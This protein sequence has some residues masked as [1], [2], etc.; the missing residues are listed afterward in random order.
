[1]ETRPYN[2]DLARHD[3]GEAWEWQGLCRRGAC[4]ASAYKRAA[5]NAPA[6]VRP[7]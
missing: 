2:D 7:R 3:G 1:M 5:A 4:G 6:L